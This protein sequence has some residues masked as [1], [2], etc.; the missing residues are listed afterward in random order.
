AGLTTREV[1]TQVGA[2]RIG[3]TRLHSAIDQ[4]ASVLTIHGTAPFLI[5]SRASKETMLLN[6]RSALDYW[7]MVVRE[8]MAVLWHFFSVGRSNPRMSPFTIVQ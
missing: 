8:M 5:A 3:G 2:L 1:K 6:K 7:C 4:P